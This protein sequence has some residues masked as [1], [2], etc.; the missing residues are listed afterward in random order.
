MCAALN[1]RHEARNQDQVGR[2]CLLPGAA[3]TYIERAIACLRRGDRVRGALVD[4]AERNA[5]GQPIW[6][7][8]A[9]GG[10]MLT[11]C[12]GQSTGGSGAGYG[13]LL[14]KCAPN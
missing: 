1:N 13:T 2:P 14:Q 9:D 4:S 8:R 10:F 6:L 3:F 11:C 5:D 12:S 7:R